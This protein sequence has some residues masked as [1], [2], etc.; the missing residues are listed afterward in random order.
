[1]T[2]A[3]LILYAGAWTL[4]TL[5]LVRRGRQAG[6]AA[7]V[8]AIPGL[9][10]AILALRER[11]GGGFS[12]VAEAFF[13]A[14]LLSLAASFVAVHVLALRGWSAGPALSTVTAGAII[15]A[16]PLA[17]LAIARFGA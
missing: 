15:A 10:C 4:A 7:S 14:L 9:A 11:P 5:A 12:G 1:M 6:Y 8:C 2:R 17:A 3:L 13:A 16:P